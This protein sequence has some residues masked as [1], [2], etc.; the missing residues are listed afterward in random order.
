MENE[1]NTIVPDM[2]DR[3]KAC[4]TCQTYGPQKSAGPAVV[5]ALRCIFFGGKVLLQG[6]VVGF[7]DHFLVGCDVDLYAPVLGTALGSGVGG[8]VVL[9]G[10]SL[11]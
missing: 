11:G 4:R 9:H 2:S 7:L 5:R 8:Y 6:A 1:I 3:R 10:K